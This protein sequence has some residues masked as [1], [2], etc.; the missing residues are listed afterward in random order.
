LDILPENGWTR[1]ICYDDLILPLQGSAAS[2]VV[3]RSDWGINAARWH[4]Y[5][6][7]QIAIKAGVIAWTDEVQKARHVNLN[8]VIF[9]QTTRKSG[10]R[11]WNSR[12]SRRAGIIPI[13]NHQ[14]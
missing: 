11:L 2:S 12:E 5:L 4:W 1:F 8:E 13:L 14:S 9:K 6:A 3:V 7:F 10:R